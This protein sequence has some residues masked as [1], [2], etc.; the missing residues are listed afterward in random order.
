MNAKKRTPAWSVDMD[1][2]EFAVSTACHLAGCY[3]VH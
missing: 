1:P 3:R 2:K